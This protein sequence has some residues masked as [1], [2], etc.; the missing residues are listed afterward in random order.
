M[1]SEAAIAEFIH[2]IFD[3]VTDGWQHAVNAVH[4]LEDLANRLQAKAL[5]DV[6]LK[7]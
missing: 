2:G 5:W 1:P 4:G 3:D 7:G 6:V